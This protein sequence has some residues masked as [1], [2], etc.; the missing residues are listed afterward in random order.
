MVR[1]I[2]FILAG[3]ISVVILVFAYLNFGISP[4]TDELWNENWVGANSSN[5]D[6][7]FSLRKDF[8]VPENWSDKITSVKFYGL[9]TKTK[10]FVNGI[11]VPS[12]ITKSD[13]EL[14]ISQ[15]L[16]YGLDNS[17][18][19]FSDKAEK[20]FR[21]VRLIRKNLVSIN[22][23]GVQIS[24]LEVDKNIA[25]ISVRI[26]VFN[27]YDESEKLDVFFEIKNSNSDIVAK[28]EIPV[29]LRGK[30]L[31]TV[32][33]V[34]N[35]DSPIFSSTDSKNLYEAEVSLVRDFQVLDVL[36]NTFKIEQI[37]QVSKK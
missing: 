29:V 31:S 24:L 11:L 17:I 26:E 9:S 12:K 18:L 3:V 28:K 21:E 25:K 35:I 6:S 14:E 36:S 16:K 8:Y 27:R 22:A 37:K 10:V 5:N 33:V 30:S 34:L 15:Y 23:N 1:K 32:S 19:L 13:C 4:R 7:K 2:R 20:S